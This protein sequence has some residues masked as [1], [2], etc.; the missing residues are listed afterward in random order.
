MFFCDFVVWGLGGGNKGG[1]LG[2]EGVRILWEMERGKEGGIFE[3]LY[4]RCYLLS[5][6]VDYV[7]VFLELNFGRGLGRDEI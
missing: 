2:V 4:F 3:I 6:N 5:V 7:S 1:N